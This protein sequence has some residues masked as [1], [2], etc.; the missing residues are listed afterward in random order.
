MK[1]KNGKIKN[2]Q[3]E[4]NKIGIRVENGKWKPQNYK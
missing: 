1:L 3:M 2:K 4:K